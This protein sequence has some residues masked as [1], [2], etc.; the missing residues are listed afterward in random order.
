M[1][2]IYWQLRESEGVE[3]NILVREFMKG[4]GKVLSEGKEEKMGERS[5]SCIKLTHIKEKKKSHV[6]FENRKYIATLY[7]KPFKKVGANTRQK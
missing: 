4:S 2:N 5:I 7:L 1:K 3:D 6:Q